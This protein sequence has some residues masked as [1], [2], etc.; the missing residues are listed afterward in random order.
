MNAKIQKEFTLI[1]GTNEEGKSS[2]WFR[3]NRKEVRGKWIN[4]M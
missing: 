4:L 3:N 2:V 1:V